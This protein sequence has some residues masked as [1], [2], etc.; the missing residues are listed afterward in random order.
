LQHLPVEPE[1]AGLFRGQR[2]AETAAE[3]LQPFGIDLAELLGR[4]LGLADLGERRLAEP[5]EDVGD[6]QT[7]KLTI[8]TPIT[9]AITALPSQFDEAFRIPRSIGPTCFCRRGGTGSCPAKIRIRSGST[10]ATGRHRV[11]K[12]S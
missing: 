9:T 10:S 4:N 1:G 8:K 11:E 5:L 12:A 2:T 6:A 3:L 7:A